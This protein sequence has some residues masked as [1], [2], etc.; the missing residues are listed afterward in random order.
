MFIRI[1]YTNDYTGVE[2]SEF[3][4]NNPGNFTGTPDGS[5]ARFNSNN[6]EY[7]IDFEQIYPAGYKYVITWRERA[8]QSGTAEIVVAESDDNT[9]F[10]GRQ[11]NVTTNATS[12]FND[13]IISQFDF[14]YIRFRLE[15]GFSS[16]DFEIDAVGVLVPL[17]DLDSDDDGIANSIDIDDDNDGILDVT[18]LNGC[19]SGNADVVI[20]ATGVFDGGANALGPFDGN[21][22]QVNLGDVLTLDLT[23]VVPASTYIRLRMQ[24]G[25]DN[26]ILVEGS[27][28]SGSGFGDG[29]T[30][31]N[32]SADND[33][34]TVS[35]FY[36]FL[37]QVGAGGARYI[38]FTRE[39]GETLIDAVSYDPQCSSVDTDGEITTKITSG[40]I[41]PIFPEK[42]SA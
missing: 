15:D 42:F 27:T 19:T 13:T 22:S 16:T 29:V 24:R 5:V 30:Y 7:I 23:D 28:S 10:S 6:D 20:L 14:Q 1:A 39:V 21:T 3:G 11:A 41:A 38:R 12:L 35:T 37:Y 33:M 2:E 31:G 36:D 25:N 18:E 34:P 8:S 17:C 32:T 26:R 9:I 4:V 40:M